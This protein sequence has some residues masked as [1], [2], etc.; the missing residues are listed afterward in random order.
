MQMAQD[1]ESQLQETIDMVNNMMAEQEAA[2]AAPDPTPQVVEAT[3]SDVEEKPASSDEEAKAEA[4][5]EESKEGEVMSKDFTRRFAKL[6]KREK[7]FRQ[8]QDEMKQM[9]AELE[10]LRS[11]KSSPNEAARE[12]EE[13]KRIARESPGELFSKLDTSWEEFNNSILSGTKKPDDYTRDASVNKLLDR[14]DQLESKLSER[15]QREVAST[16]EKAYNNFIDE[17]RTFVDTNNEDFEL[18]HTRGE[19]GL[20]AD[21]MQEH[22]N[23]T[24]QV[25]EYRQAA[26]MV[27]DHLEE[28][29]RSFFGS[30]KIANKYRDSFGN[31]AKSEAPRQPDSRPKTL[32]NSVAAVGTTTDGEAHSKPMTRDEHKAYLART[33]NFFGE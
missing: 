12:L 20:V 33:L 2:E 9:Q 21:V 26:Q 5:Q 7:S 17:I 27:E 24:G 30:K 11:S 15:E 13:I 32:S 23:S 1:S 4:S 25:M 14:I 29:A 31:E 22:Y 16:Q 6:A 18:V 3:V 19:V 8:R 10:E 28:Q